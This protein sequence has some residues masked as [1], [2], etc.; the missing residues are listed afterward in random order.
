MKPW[1]LRLKISLWAVVL[2]GATLLAIGAIL[3]WRIRHRAA[4]YPDD[5]LR[6]EAAYVISNVKDMRGGPVDWSQP[7]QRERTLGFLAGRRLVQF[8]QGG[9]VLFHSGAKLPI[10]KPGSEGYVEQLGD[11]SYRVLAVPGDGPLEGTVIRIAAENQPLDSILQ[12][13]WITLIFALPVVLASMGLGGW[14]LSRRV[15][16]PVER[17]AQ[18]ASEID[19]RT[20]DRKLP[21]PGTNDEIG[22]L[23]D[24][25]NAMFGRIRQSFAQARRFSA[26]A[27]HEL[28]TPLTIIRGEVEAALRSGQLA[29]QTE[30]T[31]LDLL[32]ET[33]RLISIVEGLL[34]LSQ[35]DAGK[36][37]FDLQPVNL[38]ALLSE[39]VEDIEIL[40]DPR[41]IT[42]TNDFQSDVLVQGNAQFLRQVALNLFDNAIKYNIPNGEIRATLGIARGAGVFTLT[43]TGVTIPEEDR[44]R[45]FDRFHRADRSRERSQ[46]G[47][48]L[49]LSI[50]REIAR[51][52]RGDITLEPAPAGRTKFQ[53]TL[54]LAEADLTQ[55]AVRR[56]DERAVVAPLADDAPAQDEPRIVV[57]KSQQ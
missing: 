11:K 24:V 13:L 25:L 12:T 3:T 44:D 26:D 22:H 23:T 16:R 18:A 2:G 17:L 31:M 29:P 32:E 51:A 7:E 46:G 52:H 37:E 1:P 36:L 57:R 5:M 28:K 30:K 20:S 10:G 19:A 15:L 39:I 43:N 27:S 53:L 14:W 21:S 33:G 9:R 34:L 35:A 48:G 42:V 8:E 49:G 6:A 4:P 55:S 54:P 38:T 45:I 41:G 56:A 40:A 47:Q 50:C